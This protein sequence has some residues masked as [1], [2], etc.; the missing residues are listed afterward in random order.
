VLRGQDIVDADADADG[1][2]SQDEL[3]AV[4]L[5]ELGYDVGSWSEVTDLEAFIAALTHTLGHIDGE[6]HCQME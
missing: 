5:A 2:V 6:G 1:E 3:A 4:G